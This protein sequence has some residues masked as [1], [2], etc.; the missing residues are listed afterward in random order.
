[1]I[2]HRLLPPLLTTSRHPLGLP[3]S[4]TLSARGNTDNIVWVHH[5]NVNVRCCDSFV[6]AKTEIA[7]EVKDT[8]TKSMAS[9]GFMIIETLVRLNSWQPL[10]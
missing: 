3:C 5:V 8:L 6:Q 1:M 2:L 4:K 7:K 9:F 10:C